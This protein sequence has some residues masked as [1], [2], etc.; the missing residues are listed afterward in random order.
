MSAALP[1]RLTPEVWAQIDA[2]RSLGVMDAATYREVVGCYEARDR[3]GYLMLLHPDESPDLAGPTAGC[4]NPPSKFRSDAKWIH[5]RDTC[6]IPM[7]AA[8]PD[9]PNWPLRL[10]QIEKILA[11]RASIPAEDRFWKVD[12]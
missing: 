5:Y 3:K 10:A 8:C 1:D 9:D 11:W 4:V 12:P 2:H 6:V 7:I